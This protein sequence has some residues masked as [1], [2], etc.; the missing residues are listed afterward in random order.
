MELTFSCETVHQKSTREDDLRDDRGRGKREGGVSDEGTEEDE[1]KRAEGL[2]RISS[3]FRVKKWTNHSDLTG[4]RRMRVSALLRL[5]VRGKEENAN[6]T[7]L[8]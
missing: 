4:P 2:E 1:T 6:P 5:C 3:A 7:H 8:R